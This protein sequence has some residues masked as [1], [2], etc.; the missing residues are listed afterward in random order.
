MELW[1]QPYIPKPE[2]SRHQSTAKHRRVCWSKSRTRLSLSPVRDTRS[3]PRALNPWDHTAGLC[4]L[5]GGMNSSLAEN[6]PTQYVKTGEKCRKV[7][8]PFE[9]KPECLSEREGRERWLAR[10]TGPLWGLSEGVHFA[11]TVASDSTLAE[12]QEYFI[13]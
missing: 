13:L 10:D 9:P 6:F 2:Q 11:T 3:E 1:Y 5:P 4:E 12:F 8:V 7:Y